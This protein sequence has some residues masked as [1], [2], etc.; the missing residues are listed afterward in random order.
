MT[1]LQRSQGLSSSVDVCFQ[2]R[3]HLCRPD[4]CTETCTGHCK[5]S[6]GQFNVPSALPTMASKLSTPLPDNEAW[7]TIRKSHSEFWWLGVCSILVTPSLVNVEEIRESSLGEV[8][9][10]WTEAARKLLIFSRDRASLSAL[11][12][13]SRT[14]LRTQKSAAKEGWCHSSGQSLQPVL[15]TLPT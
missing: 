11:L 8:A 1:E 10:M 9:W 5:L 13:M 12:Q 14:P 3:G 15:N 2:Q 4:T 7:E 6:P